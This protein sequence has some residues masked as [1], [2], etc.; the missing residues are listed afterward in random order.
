MFHGVNELRRKVYPPHRPDALEAARRRRSAADEGRR[1][2]PG[3]A[4]PDKARESDRK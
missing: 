1:A 3:T 4:R 2:A